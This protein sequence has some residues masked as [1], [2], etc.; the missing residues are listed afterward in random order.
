MLYRY[1]IALAVAVLGIGVLACNDS[2]T[3]IPEEE[4]ILAITIINSCRVIEVG[5]QCTL[6]ARAF[7]DGGSEVRNPPLLWSTTQPQVLAVEGEGE[8]A[9]VRGLRDGAAIVT[10]MVPGDNEV[11]QQANVTVVGGGG[12]GGEPDGPQL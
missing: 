12:G 8:Q 2:P 3:F 1:T 5:A 9:V 4:R 10:V 7:A 11:S 6:R